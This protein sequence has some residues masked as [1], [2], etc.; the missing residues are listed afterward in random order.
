M[1]TTSVPDLYE[2]FCNRVIELMRWQLQGD[3][4][5]NSY[6]MKIMHELF[7]FRD[8]FREMRGGQ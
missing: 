7:R 6:L 8:A 5:D 1:R 2:A 4:C 3:K